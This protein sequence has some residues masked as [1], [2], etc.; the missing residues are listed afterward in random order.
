MR[1]YP[2]VTTIDIPAYPQKIKEVA[3]LG[4]REVCV[5]PTM[6]DF[7]ERKKMYRLLAK[8]AVKYVPL[9][10]LRN[11]CRPDEIKYFMTR[12]KTR[13]FN[14]HSRGKHPLFYNL[15]AYKKFIY[16]ENSHRPFQRGEIA[17][18]A[19]LCL[20]FAHLEDLRLGEKNIFDHYRRLAKKYFIGCAHLSA[21]KPTPCFSQVD[22]KFIY[23]SHNF[24]VLSE[25]DYLNRY[26]HILPSVCAIE[27]NSCIAEQI[28]VKKYLEKFL[29]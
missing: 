9:V 7:E 13:H 29:R 2:S 18:W 28:R 23:D 4:L 21:I 15:T 25:F 22:N 16:L 24:S 26:R 6:I 10:H 27:L 11:D 3:R 14:I 20:D 5:F 17:H 8:T 1:V 19:G 12:Y